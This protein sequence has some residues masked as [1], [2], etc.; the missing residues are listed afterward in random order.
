V[1]QEQHKYADDDA[2]ESDGFVADLVLAG[3]KG[4]IALCCHTRT[5]NFKFPFNLKVNVLRL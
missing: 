1:R 2:E 3:Y 5:K 4:A